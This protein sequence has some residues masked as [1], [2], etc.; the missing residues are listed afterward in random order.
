MPYTHSVTSSSLV[1]TT[2]GKR[3][4]A[5]LSTSHLNLIGYRTGHPNI[6]IEDYLMGRN[7]VWLY[8][9]PVSWEKREVTHSLPVVLTVLMRDA[10]QVFGRE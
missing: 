4:S 6:H 2:M 8:K 7:W 10:S 3:Y 5:D 1:I 9:T